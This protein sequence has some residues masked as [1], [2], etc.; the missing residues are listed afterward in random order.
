ML[1]IPDPWIWGAFLL[2][3]LSTAACVVYGAL[4]WNKGAENEQTQIQEEKNRE[5][6]TSV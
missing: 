6:A 1:G 5:K 3:V 2:C 4:N